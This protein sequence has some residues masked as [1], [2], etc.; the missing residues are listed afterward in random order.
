MKKFKR[1]VFAGTVFGVPLD[2]Q[3]LCLGKVLYSSEVWKDLIQ[4][5]I[6]GEVIARSTTPHRL[7]ACFDKEYVALLYT[8]AAC[9]GSMWPILGKVEVE[10]QEQTD[11]AE[12]RVGDQI[13][14]GDQ[15]L[16][17]ATGKEI[18]SMANMAV[19]G[20]GSAELY[21]RSI[22]AKRNLL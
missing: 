12:R 11:V 13:W 10:G 6:T 17:Q 14:Q 15:L 7:D 22:L 18:Q 1:T 4:V 20:C 21:I 3:R 2:S 9:L 19:K 5:G 8:S 16:R